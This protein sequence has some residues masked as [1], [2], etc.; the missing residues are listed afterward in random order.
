MEPSNGPLT[1]LLKQTAEGVPHYRLWFLCAEPELSDP[2]LLFA[3]L[4]FSIVLCDLFT[5]RSIRSSCVEKQGLYG[6]YFPS[7]GVCHSF[8]KG[9]LPGRYIGHFQFVL[10]SFTRVLTRAAEFFQGCC[11][12]MKVVRTLAAIVT[13]ICS[14]LC[15]MSFPNTVAE[16]KFPDK[17]PGTHT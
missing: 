12:L 4:F 16:N 11:V 13:R 8:F 9:L 14:K 6:F 5:L 7:V 10:K 1:D 15:N 3:G 2:G 17:K